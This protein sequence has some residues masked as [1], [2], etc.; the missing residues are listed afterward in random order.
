LREA[1]I[2]KGA[3]V[4]NRPGRV[5]FEDL[6]ADII[7]EYKANSRRSLGHLERRIAL[8]LRP[9]FGGRRASTI[10][11]SDIRAYI[12]SRQMPVARDDGTDMPG[13]SNAEI[14]RELAA[15]KRIYPGR[16]G[17]ENAA[18]PAHTHARGTLT[19]ERAFRGDQFE[20]ARTHHDRSVAG[21]HHH[22][23]SPAGAPSEVPTLQWS[24]VISK[25]ALRL[26]RIPPKRRRPQFSVRSAPRAAGGVETQR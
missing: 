26:S 25:P 12:A 13:A 2:V 10:T 19:S 4:T 3:P 14:N 24:Q 6:A 23:I 5:R 18:P 20:A 16:P 22:R 7:N 9:Y 11:T 15:L 8:H 21:G 17:R 1:A